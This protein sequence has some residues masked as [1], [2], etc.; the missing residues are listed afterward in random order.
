VPRPVPRFPSDDTGHP[1]PL[2]A[3]KPPIHIP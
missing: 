3:K 2:P 1:R